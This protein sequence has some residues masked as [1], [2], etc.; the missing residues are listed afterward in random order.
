MDLNELM[1]AVATHLAG[2]P[3]MVRLRDPQYAGLSGVTHKATTGQIVVDVKSTLDNDTFLRVFLHEVAHAKMHARGFAESNVNQPA[4]SIP[5][6]PS[7]AAVKARDR[8][9][10]REAELLACKWLAWARRH[11]WDVDE[12]GTEMEG[13]LKALLK[14]EEK[15]K[16]K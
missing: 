11:L 2:K 9:Q 14:Y 1:E 16:R 8:Q 4:G 10:E 7:T 15:E 5:R 12:P 3:V 13:L 6:Q